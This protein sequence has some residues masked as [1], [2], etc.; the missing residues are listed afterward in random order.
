MM[1]GII[2]SPSREINRKCN[3]ESNNQV[4]KR[5][6]LLLRFSKSLNGY[7][8]AD[9]RCVLTTGREKCWTDSYHQLLYPQEIYKKKKHLKINTH[10]KIEI[11]TLKAKPWN[12]KQFKWV[13]YW[14]LKICS[15]RQSHITQQDYN[16]NGIHERSLHTMDTDNHKIKG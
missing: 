13:N 6:T 11:N 4:I 9:L 3:K 14:V 12:S 2:V 10:S 8:Q 5:A 7:K 15:L 1:S 16:T